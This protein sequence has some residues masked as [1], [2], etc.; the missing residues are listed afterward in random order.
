MASSVSIG[1]IA[2]IFIIGGFFV[3]KYINQDPIERSVIQA[4]KIEQSIT[5]DT[6]IVTITES[7][8]TYFK[9]IVTSKSDGTAQTIIGK[10]ENGV[11]TFFYFGI[12]RPTCEIITI[13]NIPETIVGN[14]K[15]YDGDALSVND[16]KKK[17]ED[18]IDETFS[19]IGFITSSDDP[20]NG[21]TIITSGDDTISLP[22]TDTGIKNNEVV[23]VIVTETDGV[24]VVDSVKPI[25][26]DESDYSDTTEGDN[27]GTV[28]EPYS[29]SIP[30]NDYSSYDVNKSGLLRIINH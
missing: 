19:I 27:T 28:T 13:Y 29:G 1:F 12:E 20:S 8:G 2:V 10:F 14:C 5:Q 6:H 30:D 4:L 25:Q 18:N 21:G 11:A 9:G 3:F 17:I 7:D 26:N 23:V 24:I 16:A 22:V 15:V